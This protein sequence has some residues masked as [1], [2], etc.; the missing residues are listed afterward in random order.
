[1][2]FGDKRVACLGPVLVPGADDLDGRDQ[3][4]GLGQVV[5][6]DLVFGRG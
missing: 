6:P 3:A 1:M 2:A 5:H 4:A